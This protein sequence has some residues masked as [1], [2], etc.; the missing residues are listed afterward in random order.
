M[1]NKSRT[2]EQN[3]LWC[4]SYRQRRR[5]RGLCITCPNQL[6]EGATGMR[7]DECSDK[8]NRA[9]VERLR[10]KRAGGVS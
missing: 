5:D 9:N 2:N 10:R 7:C 4:R 6:P 3:R 8:A 1:G